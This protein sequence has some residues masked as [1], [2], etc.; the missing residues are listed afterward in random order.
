[1][2]KYTFIEFLAAYES[3]SFDAIE[4]SA[5]T[6]AKHFLKSHENVWGEI[7]GGD[8]TKQAHYMWIML[9]AIIFRRL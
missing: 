9:F 1:M 3:E 4:E 6:W 2:A 7:H 8:C 5:M